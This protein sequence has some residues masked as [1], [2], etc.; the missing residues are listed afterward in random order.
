MIEIDSDFE[1]GHG[2]NFKEVKKGCWQVELDPPGGW[3]FVRIKQQ[4]EKDTSPISLKISCNDISLFSPDRHKPGG[5]YSFDG[6]EWRKIPDENINYNPSWYLLKLPDIPKGKSMFVASGVPYTNT[7]LENYLYK[8]KDNKYVTIEKVGFSEEDRPILCIK[9]SNADISDL[10]KV[11]IFITARYDAPESAATWAAQGVM[12]FLLSGKK[13]AEEILSKYIIYIIPIA[14]PDGVQYGLQLGNV[15][16]TCIQWDY[17]AL[18]QKESRAIWKKVEEVKPDHIFDFHSYYTR[19]GMRHPYEGMYEYPSNMTTFDYPYFYAMVKEV[20]EKLSYALS[21]HGGKPLSHVLFEGGS[22]LISKDGLGLDAWDGGV[23]EYF[24]SVAY[25]KLHCLSALF[26]F[27]Y[28]TCYP[29]ETMKHGRE[30]FTTILSLFN[31]IWPGYPNQGPPNREIKKLSNITLFAWGDNMEEVRDSRV[32]LWEKRDYIKIFAEQKENGIFVDTETLSP[33]RVHGLCVGPK[34]FVHRKA[35]LRFFLGEREL[36]SVRVDD[37]ESSNFL[38]IKDI[39]GNW[40]FV[41]IR[42]GQ[43]VSVLFQEKG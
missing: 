40:V 42:I 17:D 39:Q 15:N 20:K 25:K 19:K 16:G 3:F 37:E 4:G 23:N 11:V 34:R 29:E 5:Y 22:G 28:S 27:N 2:E 32:E 21:T 1:N 9:I 31:R 41:P 8:I 7:D 33:L 14:N 43:K 36:T 30:Y 10:D 26:E 38:K 12:D 24:V 35:A 13:E 18:S 6:R